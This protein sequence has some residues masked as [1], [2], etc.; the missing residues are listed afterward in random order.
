MGTRASLMAMVVTDRHE[1][2]HVQERGYVERPGRIGAIRA[3]LGKTG[4]FQVVPPAHFGDAWVTAVHDPTFVRYLE[5]VCSDAAAGRSVYPYVV[6]I[7]NTHRPPDD[8]AMRAG[9]HCIDTFTPLHRGAWVAARRAVDCALTAA[10]ELGRGSAVAYALVRPPGHHAERSHYGGFC[11]LNN[12]AVAAAYLC[13]AGRVAMLDIDYHHGN[14][15]QSIF[16]GRSDVLTVSIHGHPRFA[17]PY[18]AG[19][20]D[21][22]GE[23]RGA[24]Y[25][26]NYPLP[27]RVDA[28]LYLRTLRA[29]LGRIRG[30]RPA[31]LVVCLGLDTARG[32]PTGTWPLRA[33][34]YRDVGAAIGAL[35]LPTLVVQEGGYLRRSLGANA[36]GFFTG[37]A[38]ACAS[39]PHG[40]VTAGNP[41]IGASVSPS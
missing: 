26:A 15:Q 36:A 27:E 7:R 12:A 37:L 24:G 22:A 31:S 34:D 32:D 18:F 14:G 38:D 19:F 16:N 17:Y 21:E 4:L 13:R 30:F 41:S 35:R 28:P 10:R 39:S 8:L 6:P 40:R 2:H 9:Y 23:G 1:V 29:A 20:R 5:R 25:N 11:Y 33:A 3:A